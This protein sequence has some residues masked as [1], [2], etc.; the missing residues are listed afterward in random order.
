MK[1]VAI[2]SQKGGA[3]KTTLALHLAVA[4]HL[5]GYDTGLIDLD[6]QGTAET[7]GGWRQDE[8]PAVIGAKAA[9]LGKTLDKARKAGVDLVTIGQWLG[10]ASLNTT[11]KYATLDLE[12]KRQAL[13]QAKPLGAAPKSTAPWR[14]DPTILA[15]LEG[16]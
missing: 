1:T 7:W 16:L 13:A 4:G 9:T 3:G 15:W 8:P 2:I 10:H 12:M 14:K 5:A 11:T 6:P